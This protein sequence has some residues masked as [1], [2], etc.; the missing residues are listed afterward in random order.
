LGGAFQIRD[1]PKKGPGLGPGFGV[2]TL[3]K[4]HHFKHSNEILVYPL[5]AKNPSSFFCASNKLLALG[6]GFSFFK[7][8]TGR[9]RGA[10]FTGSPLGKVTKMAAGH[11]FLH[12]L[13]TLGRENNGILSTQYGGEQNH[14]RSD[15]SKVANGRRAR[16]NKKTSLG[17]DPAAKR[18]AL[19]FQLIR[20]D[21]Y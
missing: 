4:L 9:P 13:E 8:K 20:T 21:W 15:I 1:L 7:Q 16:G 2:S 19:D 11:G 12:G 6:N 14:L 18:R 5:Q 3:F 17:G 10:L